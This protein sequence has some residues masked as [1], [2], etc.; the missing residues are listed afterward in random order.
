M[1]RRREFAF[2]TELGFK[3][4]QSEFDSEEK[5]ASC[6][7]RFPSST[8]PCGLSCIINRLYFYLF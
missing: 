6:G 2:F 7:R 1:F 3:L 5:L 4:S 8:W